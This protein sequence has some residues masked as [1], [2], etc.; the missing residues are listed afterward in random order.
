MT[1]T[2]QAIRVAHQGVRFPVNNKETYKQY[3]QTTHWRWV[4]FIFLQT[5][6]RCA[7]CRGSLDLTVHHKSYKHLW[8]ECMEDL[9]AMCWDCHKIKHGLVGE[10]VTKL[11]RK[12]K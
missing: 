8:K 12:L 10:A 4:R 5:N 11:M 6:P 2:T 3:L 1:Q 7:G 9:E